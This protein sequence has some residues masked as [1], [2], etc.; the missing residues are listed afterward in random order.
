[1]YN[2]YEGW[3]NTASG[4]YKEGKFRPYIISIVRA[5]NVQER[6]QRERPYSLN[7]R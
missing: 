7:H 6:K 1:M 2:N 3:H 4:Q 5:N